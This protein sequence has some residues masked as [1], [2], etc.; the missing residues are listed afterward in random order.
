MECE[1]IE[2]IGSTEHEPF[3]RLEHAVVN[4]IQKAEK[5][6]KKVH[7]FDVLH[8]TGKVHKGRIV[9]LRVDVKLAID[10]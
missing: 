3:I 6:G 1:I 7:S 2:V 5:A 4:A 10:E 9:E 8:I